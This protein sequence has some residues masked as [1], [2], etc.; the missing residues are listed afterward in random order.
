VVLSEPG[1]AEG[2]D[3]TVLAAEPAEL[4]RTQEQEKPTRAQAKRRA[5]FEMIRDRY[6]KGEYMSTI[7]RDLGLDYRTVRKYA[8]S[9]ECP[10]RK[11]YPKRGRMVDPYEPYI[12]TRFDEGC[13][14]GVQ[15][16]REIIEMGYPGSR[17][18]VAALIAPL[19][20]E[21]NGGKRPRTPSAAGEPLKPRKASMLLL[22]REERRSESESAAL[23][24][25]AKVHEEI[26][27][28][29]GFTE[30]FTK[31]VRERRS[32]ELGQWLS[33]AEASGIRE[34]RQFARGV[35]Q[36]EAAV[37]AGCTLP[38]SNGQTEG[39][40]TKLKAI[41]RSMYGRAKFD[42]LR[43]RALYAA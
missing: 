38:Y 37:E 15:L 21:E 36:D 7:A 24:R 26:A 18:Q 42:L 6:A 25:L 11:P 17:S 5:R 33:D 1:P 40:I 28:T 16:H 29:V 35:R 30:R 20:R 39:Q 43:R 10:Q 19:R 3:S 22:R 8:L 41:K 34:I 13:K 27:A 4:R 9:D 12:R 2:P 23:T 31:I 14:N 32:G